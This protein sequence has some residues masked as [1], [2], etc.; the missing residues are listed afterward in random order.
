MDAA[1][2]PKKNADDLKKT[3]GSKIKK[4]TDG[5]Y[6]S[7]P[8]LRH[9]SFFWNTLIPQP[10][11]WSL[12]VPIAL[13]HLPKCLRAEPSQNI[14]KLVPKQ[15]LPRTN[16]GV[17]GKEPLFLCNRA[18]EALLQSGLL[19]KIFGLPQDLNPLINIR[20]RTRGS[21]QSL[22]DSKPSKE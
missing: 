3:S 20:S 7:K 21:S 12:P 4:K 2:I 14:S 19:S 16:Q 15:R 17:C 22:Q 5:S 8:P 18:S 13:A 1:W 10:N 6:T 11:H 9:E